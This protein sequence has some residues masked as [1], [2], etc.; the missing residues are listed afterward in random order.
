MP[1]NIMESSLIELP[2]IKWYEAIIA[3]YNTAGRPLYLPSLHADSEKLLP[4]HR[5]ED[6]G[7]P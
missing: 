2:G 3:K 6:M 5:S 1:I 7:E 4:N